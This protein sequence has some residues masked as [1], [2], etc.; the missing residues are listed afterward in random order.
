MHLLALPAFT[1]NYVWMLHD[2][3]QAWVVDPGDAAPVA[4]ALDARV[5]QLQGILVTHHHP[6]HVGG[7]DALRTRLQAVGG[8]VHGPASERMP[9]PCVRHAEGDTIDV[10]GHRFEVLDVPGHTAGHIAYLQRDAHADP[11]LF[12]GDTLFS[13]GCGR[14]FE[15]TP[16]QMAASLARLAALP[17]G[18]RVCCTHEYTLSNLR[19]AAAVE[20]DNRAREAYAAQCAARR[21]SGEP[22]LP[23]TIGVENAVNPFLRCSEPQV[24]AAARGQGC[25]GDDPVDVFAALRSWKDR[26]R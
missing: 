1:D 22:T 7:V 14:L 13:A 5:L 26:F 18:T 16:A 6:D 19:F 15:G 20:P 23:S 21:A 3:R 12:C 11:L 9:E 10:L 17:P 8:S 25:R 24:I 2:G 4:A